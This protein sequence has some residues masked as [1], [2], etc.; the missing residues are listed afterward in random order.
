[1]RCFYIM[2]ST[3]VLSVRVLARRA[4]L[5]NVKA[6]WPCNIVRFPKYVSLSVNENIYRTL[7]N[8]H[9]YDASL[10]HD[11]VI[12]WKHFPRYWPFVRRI[13][14]SSVNSPHKGQWRGALMFI[15]ICARLNGW[16]NNGEAGDL[17]RNRAHYDVMVMECL[18]KAIQNSVEQ[19]YPATHWWGIFRALDAH[20]QFW[21]PAAFL[22]IPWYVR[23][24]LLIEKQ[25]HLL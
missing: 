14:R 21:G 10:K 9:S 19:L 1:M 12:K 4:L 22:F 23:S 17:R 25:K 24:F 13:H 20:R 7:N 5:S 16:V 3:M 6:I 8:L 18:R 2:L 11:D 15:L